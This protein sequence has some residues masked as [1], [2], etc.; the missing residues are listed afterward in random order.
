MNFGQF[1][2]FI[3]LSVLS[4]EAV[5]AVDYSYKYKD[6][7]NN[8]GA[9]LSLTNKEI[10]PCGNGVCDSGETCHSCPIDCISHTPVCGDGICEDGESCETCDADCNGELVDASRG[11]FCCYGGDEKPQGLSNAAS[12]SDSRCATKIWNCNPNPSLYCCGDGTCNGEETLGNCEIDGCTCGN[13]VCDD[14]ED[15]DNCADDCKCNNNGICEEGETP[16]ACS[17]DCSCGNYKCEP[18]LGE[19]VST[20]EHD[21][22][23]NRNFI[24]ESHENYEHCPEDCKKDT[25]ED[26][27]D[28]S[29]DEE[30]EDSL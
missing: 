29:N 17:L 22:G 7:E 4:F 19:T 1:T 5:T 16:A 26:L 9:P 20:C 24:C 10:E 2:L 23:C 27:S 3:L 12:C 30:M 13:G 8:S 21:C 28:A 11:L 6:P 14:G 25:S 18:E 15:A